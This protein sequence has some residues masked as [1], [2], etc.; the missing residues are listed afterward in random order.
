MYNVK[1]ITYIIKFYLLSLS[2]HLTTGAKR[3]K[4]D[5][6]FLAVFDVHV[7]LCP[8]EKKVAK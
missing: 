7:V 8:I 5:N 3:F 4:E 6:D 1:I 2:Y